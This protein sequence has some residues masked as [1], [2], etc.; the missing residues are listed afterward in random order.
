MIYDYIIVGG[1]S[2][3]CVLANRLS[4]APEKSVLLIEAGA[5]T[6]PGLEP[7]EILDTYPGRAFFNPDLCW[8]DL[9]VY[10]QPI[11]HNENKR[12][13][14]QKYEQGRV[15]GGSSS[16]NGMVAVRGSSADYN[17][18]EQL[19]ATGWG[20]DGV[21]PYFTR[22][23]HDLDFDGPHHNQT[24]P[25]P[26]R[27]IFPAQWDGITKAAAAAFQKTGF[28]YVADMN[29]EFTEGYSPA[30]F[31]AANGRRVT[32]AMAYLGASVRER[33][34][35]EIATDTTVRII[36]FEGKRATGVEVDRPDGPKHVRGRNVIICC[37]AFH[38]P[39]VLMRSGV[40]PAAEIEAHG[41]STVHDLPGVGK[42]LQDHACISVSSYLPR[43]ARWNPKLGRHVLLH[44]RYS[45]HHPDTPTTDM[46]LSVSS[47]SA[48][49]PLG[50]QLGTFQVF[51]G[52]SFSRGEVL[53]NSADWRVE[54]EIRLNLLSDYRDYDR[55]AGGVRLINDLL[56]LE[57][58]KST[59]LNPF[60][61]SYSGAARRVSE[62]TLLNRLLMRIMASLMDGPEY[63]RR[64]IIHSAITGGNTLE[65]LINN[66]QAME[67]WIRARV[68]AAWHPCGTCKM[69][70]NGDPLAVL[71]EQGRVR[72]MDGLWVADA[73]VMPEIPRANTNIPTIM[74]AEKLSDAI[75][76][77]SAV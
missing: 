58:L 38:T 52:K 32:S 30:P 62:R 44:L 49:H 10:F 9:K 29:A 18:W 17:E 19:G 50:A 24:G 14:L 2:A 76:A 77:G 8:S 54:P 64:Q 55:L 69:G 11:S 5:D 46:V 6:P 48:W 60:P 41:I 75:A 39:A 65:K 3:G 12:P 31:N 70:F 34:N 21:K 28:E 63:L 47:R 1:G 7:E 15:L 67:N 25:L 56:K 45:S 72:G 26:I 37:G 20:W 53:L 59:A 16:I 68:T 51:M 57:P 27:R 73:S 43:A 61:S 35:L 23:E 36:T 4:K 71:D 33:K 22:L 42:G 13:P 40:G 74:I 66:S